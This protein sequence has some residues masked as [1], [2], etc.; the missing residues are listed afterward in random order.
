MRNQGAVLQPFPLPAGDAKRHSQRIGV[1]DAFRGLAII[2]VL[3]FHYTFRWGP[4]AP[5]G[6]DLLGSG[7]GWFSYGWL[8]VEF[9]FII[10]GFVIFMTAEKS[11]DAVDFVIGRF[12]RIYPTFIFCLTVSFL[13]ELA[14]APEPMRG[15][16]AQYIVGFTM[17][18][19]D[20]GVPWIDGA[21]WSLL[22]E[23]KFYFWVA[24]LYFGLK[25]P[26]VTSW[27]VFCVAGVAASF[28]SYALSSRL[29]IAQW[30]PFFSVGMAYYLR[31][32]N[33]RTDANAVA[34]YAVAA[35]SYVVLWVWRPVQNLD[36]DPIIVNTA[37]AVMVL[38]FEA[39]V[40]GWLGRLQ[41]PVLLY[42]GLISYPLYLLH[43]NIGVSLIR[44]FNQLPLLNGIAA[45]VLATALVLGMTAMVHR[46]VED[47]SRRYVRRRLAQFRRLPASAHP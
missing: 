31:F 34:L 33:G 18:S 44:S 11:R 9:F 13:C 39:F 27:C 17:Q 29:M 23:L 40:R 16:V 41:T 7:V 25:R 14:F 43:D 47:P 10:S 6:R 46:Y 4:N 28:V 32:R 15:T 19:A 5:D 8:G 30:T 3:L 37:I 24:V 42:V 26:F 38:L 20:F 22:V 2:S 1:L 45:F 12:S 21:Y 36:D 35:F